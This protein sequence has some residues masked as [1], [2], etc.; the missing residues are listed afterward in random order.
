MTKIYI[1]YLYI[2]YCYFKLIY[3]WTIRLNS[4]CSAG[5]LVGILS[6]GH[7]HWEHLDMV[8]STHLGFLINKHKN[9]LTDISVTSS[10]I[11]PVFFPGLLNL[12]F[13]AASSFKVI[14]KEMS[15]SSHF[16]LWVRSSEKNATKNTSQ[17]VTEQ[18]QGASI[19]D[20]GVSLPDWLLRFPLTTHS[21]WAHLF[22]I[23]PPAW[24]QVF[25]TVKWEKV[26]FFPAVPSVYRVYHF[27][28]INF[29]KRPVA[30][31]PLFSVTTHSCTAISSHPWF[32]QQLLS[33][34][35]TFSPCTLR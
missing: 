19:S 35:S 4:L 11:H 30:L 8:F 17:Y 6:C 27:T 33:S 1:I 21:C 5:L 2:I 16:C 28:F 25:L 31:M 7:S 23:T 22:S 34:R 18:K 9:M 14:L 12:K 13:C 3:W 24:L 20:A 26:R 15:N 29:Y 32:Q 10:V